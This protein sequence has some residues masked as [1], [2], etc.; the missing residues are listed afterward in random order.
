MRHGPLLACQLALQTGRTSIQ[1]PLL[2]S[3]QRRLVCVRC[4]LLVRSAFA[5]RVRERRRSQSSLRGACARR[6]SGFFV[7]PARERRLKA[8][9]TVRATARLDCTGAS[10]ELTVAPTSG[11][12][13]VAGARRSDA[14]RM[15]RGAPRL[16]GAACGLRRRELRFGASAVHSSKGPTTADAPRRQHS[17]AAPQRGTPCRS[18]TCASWTVGLGSRTPTGSSS[19]LP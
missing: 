11:S 18:L 13:H 15:P 4:A 8:A 10:A 9:A 17:A 7:S 1:R 16:E 5:Q 3:C 12:R 19:T 2:A 14:C 6:A